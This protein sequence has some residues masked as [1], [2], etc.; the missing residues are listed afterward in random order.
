MVQ[1]GYVARPNGLRGAVVAH[2]DPTMHDAV[3]TGLELEIVPRAAA[4]LRA[5]VVSV[6]P[7][8]GGLRL[9]LEGIN[10]RNASESLVGATIHV[11]RDKLANLGDDAWLDT[12]IVGLRVVTQDGTELGRVG[13]VLPTGA[14]DIY[15][16]RTAEGREIMVPAVAHAVLAVDL[17]AGTMTVS[18][19]AIEYND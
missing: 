18:A 13:E 11:E 10:D 5:R 14:N 6:A 4:P 9:T 7:V 2:V 19:D 15:V 1:L 17:E 8:R 3:T 16:V 12:D